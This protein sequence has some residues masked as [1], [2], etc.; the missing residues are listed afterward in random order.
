MFK[1]LSDVEAREFLSEEQIGQLGCIKAGFPYVIPIN[2]IFHDGNLYFHSLAGDKIEALRQNP[3][4]CLQVHKNL[5]EY[6]WRSM[7]AF[8]KYEE[9]TDADER[10]WFM[11]RI[12]VC[13]PHLTPVESLATGRESLVVIFRLR[14]TK[15]TGVAE[16]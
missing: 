10:A 9:I 1:H 14:V 5:D 3:N 2:Y 16:E 8:G 15:L 6:R 11:R 12:L 13:F 7:I 4:A